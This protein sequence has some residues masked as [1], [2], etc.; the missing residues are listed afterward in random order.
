MRRLVEEVAADLRT[1][2][3]PDFSRV[4]GAL[5]QEDKS[6]GFHARMTKIEGVRK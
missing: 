2:A 4:S 3:S 1:E 5:K 6:K